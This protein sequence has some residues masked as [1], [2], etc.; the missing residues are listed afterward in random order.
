MN[1]VIERI[2]TYIKEEAEEYYNSEE[3]YNNCDIT[4]NMKCFNNVSDIEHELYKIL[5][6]DYSKIYFKKEE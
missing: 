3:N 1:E 2:K 6:K 4:S 5:L